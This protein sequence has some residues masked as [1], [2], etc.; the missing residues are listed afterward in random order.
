MAGITIR[1]FWIKEDAYYRAFYDRLVTSIGCSNISGTPG[2]LKLVEDN[3]DGAWA[4]FTDA[5][6]HTWGWL[7]EGYTAPIPDQSPQENCAESEA[8]AKA[9]PARPKLVPHGVDCPAE[10]YFA[11]SEGS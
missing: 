7:P 2:D 1:L 11:G 4:P 9:S 10:S 6:H 3:D 8:Y 5:S